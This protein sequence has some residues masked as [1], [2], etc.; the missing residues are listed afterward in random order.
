MV[1]KRDKILEKYGWLACTSNTSLVRETT[2]ETSMLNSLM[3]E[4]L[5]FKIYAHPPQPPKFSQDE[6]SLRCTTQMDLGK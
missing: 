4:R 5:R 3:Y 6:I 1:D 2:G